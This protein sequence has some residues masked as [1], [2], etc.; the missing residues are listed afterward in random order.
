MA[1]LSELLPQEPDDL[2]VAVGPHAPTSV[3]VSAMEP[4]L[5][6]HLKNG[7]FYEVARAYEARLRQ[8]PA[9]PTAR[10]G[11]WLVTR[12]EAKLPTL[13]EGFLGESS[14]EMAHR[15]VALVPGRWDLLV[16]LAERLHHGGELAAAQ[17]LLHHVEEL[18]SAPDDV[19]QKAC[20]LAAELQGELPEGPWH[21]DTNIDVPPPTPEVYALRVLAS[22]CLLVLLFLAGRWA[23][24]DRLVRAGEVSLLRAVMVLEH[25][26]Q[27]TPTVPRPTV[28][29]ETAAVPTEL[30]FPEMRNA[31]EC[32][33]FA[34]EID[35]TAFRPLW[36]RERLLTLWIGLEPDPLKRQD[37]K[38]ARD[39]VRMRISE[40]D[41]TGVHSEEE[42]SRFETALEWL[43]HGRGT[44]L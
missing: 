39:E 43:R 40:L 41:R 30:P 26:K 13:P 23:A 16:E 8:N 34:S 35:D 28:P 7:H 29:W 20:D 42:S 12:G 1:R 32:F 18:P 24:A 22:V 17:V 27:T 38:A 44:T 19:R 5:L 31:D 11:L 3:P 15:A 14:E 25:K 4:D 2:P 33:R 37:L 21:A 6:I 10:A 9:D 36:L